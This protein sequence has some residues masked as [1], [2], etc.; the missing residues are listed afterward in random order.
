MAQMCSSLVRPHPRNRSHPDRAWAA[1]H[2]AGPIQ[3]NLPTLRIRARI[4]RDPPRLRRGDYPL[5]GDNS[6]VCAAIG[7]SGERYPS[8]IVVIGIGV[9]PNTELATAADLSTLN[10][11]AVDPYLLRWRT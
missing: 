10:G 7:R 11:I 1:S 8:D 3:G 4:R 5:E 2:A 6:R 9:E